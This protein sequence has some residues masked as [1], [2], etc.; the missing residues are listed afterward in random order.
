MYGVCAFGTPAYGAE[1]LEIEPFEVDQ[2]DN[3]I[4]EFCII[5]CSGSSI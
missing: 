4:E 1:C 3:N 5:T 2:P